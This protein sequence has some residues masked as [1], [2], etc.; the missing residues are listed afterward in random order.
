[1]TAKP[2]PVAPRPFRFTREQY[3]QLGE[4]GFFTDKRVERIR[5]QIVEMSPINWPHVVG[6][7]KTALA[8]ERVFA[9]IAWVS[10]NEQPLALAES[11]PQPD[12]MAVA[13]RFEDY[14]AHPTTAL[15]VVEVADATLSRDTTEKAELY[16][17]AGIPDYWVVDVENHRLHI[18]R[19]P[20]PLPAGLGATAYRTHLTLT[21]TDRVS[22]LAA[23]GA[24]ILMSELLP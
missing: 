14:T 22:P 19:D 11:D 10:R 9:G 6:C 8:L 16:A 18:F 7:R 15:L 12:V 3:Y 21:P 2:P 5:G 1:M 24:S 13:G 4:L 17:E 23:P 20:Q